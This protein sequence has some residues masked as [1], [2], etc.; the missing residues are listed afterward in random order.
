MVNIDNGFGAAYVAHQ[1]NRLGEKRNRMQGVS[2]I[3][4][5]NDKVSLYLDC[6]SGISGDMFLGAMLD[7]GLDE[8]EF[9]TELKNFLYMTM[10]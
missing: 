10:K 2:N 3:K 8:E 4:N 1:I 6:F 7:L 5:N 9:L